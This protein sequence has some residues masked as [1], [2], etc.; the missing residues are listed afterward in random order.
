VVISC[1]VFKTDDWVSKNEP[2][3][4]ET[5][6]TIIFEETC[7]PQKI[8]FVLTAL[9]I[10]IIIVLC[11]AFAFWT[12]ELPSGLNDFEHTSSCVATTF[13]VLAAFSPVYYGLPPSLFRAHVASLVLF[14]NHTLCL[15][16]LFLPNMNFV[17]LPRNIPELSEASSQG[18]EKLLINFEETESRT[19]LHSLARPSAHNVHSYEKEAGGSLYAA[20][21]TSVDQRWKRLKFASVIDPSNTYFESEQAHQPLGK[22]RPPMCVGR[23]YRRTFTPLDPHGSPVHPATSTPAEDELVGRTQSLMAVVD[24][25][26]RKSTMADVV[27]GVL[28]QSGSGSRD[29]ERAG[30]KTYRRSSTVSMASAKFKRLSK[31]DVGENFKTSSRRSSRVSMASAKAMKQSVISKGETAETQSS[32]A[33]DDLSGTS[34]L[35]GLSK[36]SVDFG[37]KVRRPSRKS[38]TISVASAK[39]RKAGIPQVKTPSRKSSKVSLVSARFLKVSVISKD[40]DS[41]LAYDDLS[42]MPTHSVQSEGDTSFAQDMSDMSIEFGTKSG[43]ERDA[44]KASV[45]ST[46]AN[47]T[48]KA[49]IRNTQ[50]N[51]LEEA[52]TSAPAND[53]YTEIMS[54]SHH[55]ADIER[56]K[57]SKTDIERATDSK[58]KGKT[59]KEEGKNSRSGSGSG[60]KRKWSRRQNDFEKD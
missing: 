32:L 9:Y 39:S 50:A 31:P 23:V 59:S 42:E 21:S 11:L 7:A 30:E 27:L 20:K 46:E 24:R 43:S 15:G 57:D 37:E 54:G 1:A 29:S 47:D 41:S 14:I 48:K 38:S 44:E 51:D 33:Q 40:Q 58:G 55:E 3:L 12:K 16:F 49:S 10:S 18:D 4:D 34:T 26:H 22:R 45:R 13:L 53:L 5:S 19:F 25:P 17:F 28:N 6:G 35:S 2:R 8:F 60:E 36:K 56:A 52:N